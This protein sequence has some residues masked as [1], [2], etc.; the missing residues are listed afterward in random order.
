VKDSAAQS[1]TNG[2]SSSSPAAGTAPAVQKPLTAK[3]QQA[4]DLR[5][6]GKTRAEGAVIMGISKPVYS[7][8]LQAAYKKLGLSKKNQT[9]SNVIEVKDP[10]RAAAVIDAATDPE[11]KLESIAKVFRD[12]GL[13]MAASA[14]LLR[15]IRQKYFGVVEATKSLKSGEIVDALNHKI[16]LA[17]RYMDDKT[18]SE[19]SFRDLA[20]GTAAMIEKRQLLRGEPTQIISDAERA[21]LHEL[22]PLAIAEAQRRGLTVE[23]Q[24][25]ERS[26]EPA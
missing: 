12:Y 6:A 14:A 15:R 9:P 2:L 8:T 18:M 4:F 17:L 10:E 20:L 21:K 11:A 3:Q 7:K 13:P 16:D 25:T 24:V 26:I 1:S 22:L 23:G 5:Q 19:A